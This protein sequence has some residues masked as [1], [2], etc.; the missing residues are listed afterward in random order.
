MKKIYSLLL[1]ILAGSFAFAQVTDPFTGTGALNANGWTTHS[2]TAGQL[3]ITAGS[4]SYPGLAAI[5]NKAALVAGNSEDVNKPSAVA[6]TGVAYFSAVVNLPNTTGLHASGA[7]GDYSIAAGATSGAG[8]TAFQ[9]RIYFR[10]GTVADTFNVGIL[11]NSGGTVTPS[12]LP[13]DYPINTPLFLVVKYDFTSNTASL[14]VN[15][16][17]DGAETAA[18]TTNNTG[19]TAAPTQIASII[20]RQG[21]SASIGTGNVEYDN[22]RLGASWSYVTSAVLSVREN[23]IAGLKLYPNPVVNG[24][25]YISSDLNSEKAVAIYDVL[26]KQVLQARIENETVN[27]SG[28]NSGV[29]IVKII[30]QGKTATRKLVIK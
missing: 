30:E 24:K 6:I 7:T 15:P 13:T 19:T 16:A 10:A 26:G 23:N 28:L 20:I 25:L 17:L 27:V 11:N 18:N 14:W 4:L 8:V 22:V 9:G 21:G 12:Y 1:S 29:Y 2:G 3:M 5:G